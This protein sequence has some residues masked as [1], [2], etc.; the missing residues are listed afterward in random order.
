LPQELHQWLRAAFA[1]R[2]VSDYEFKMTM[3]AADVAIMQTQSEQFL[4]Q[5]EEFLRNAGHL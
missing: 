4:M 3:D 1:K 5:T 2:Q